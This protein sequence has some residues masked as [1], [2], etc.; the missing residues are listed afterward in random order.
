MFVSS[1]LDERR[2]FLVCAILV[3]FHEVA[4]ADKRQYDHEIEEYFGLLIGL[5]ISV[6]VG[7]ILVIKLWGNR[8]DAASINAVYVNL[9]FA[10]SQ[11]SNIFFSSHEKKKIHL[12]QAIFFCNLDV[13][14]F[15]S[16]AFLSPFPQRDTS[17]CALKLRRW[18][19][20]R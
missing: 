1:L 2:I 4:G 12:R 3:C 6:V 14:I 15:K 9:M 11:C 8:K 19:H 7:T 18:K 10:T 13:Y 5:H 17:E 20:S 16:L